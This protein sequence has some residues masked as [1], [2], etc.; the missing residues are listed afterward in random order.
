MVFKNSFDEITTFMY[1]GGSSIFVDRLGIVFTGGDNYTNA[2]FITSR[3]NTKFN[4]LPPYSV[5]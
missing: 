3:T 1:K 5:L 2:T 4:P